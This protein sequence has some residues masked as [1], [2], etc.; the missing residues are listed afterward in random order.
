MLVNIVNHH[1]PV[2]FGALYGINPQGFKSLGVSEATPILQKL[3]WDTLI[4]EPL[5]G[6][7][8]ER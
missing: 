8:A 4:N 6:T 1:S 5:R 7:A 3:A 2:W